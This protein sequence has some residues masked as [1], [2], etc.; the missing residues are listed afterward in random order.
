MQSQMVEQLQVCL[1]ISDLK[2]ARRASP[3]IGAR[4]SRASPGIAARR[5]W[6]LPLRSL[7]NRDGPSG[8]FP[9]QRKL[10]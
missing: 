5:P 6:A 2:S 7:A 9:R 1:P 8:L 10:E 3:G 4:R